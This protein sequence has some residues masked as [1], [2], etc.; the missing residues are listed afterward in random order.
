[1]LNKN[2]SRPHVIIFFFTFKKKQVLTCSLHVRDGPVF[3]GKCQS[4]KKKKKEKGEIASVK[5]LFAEFAR[6]VVKVIMI[7]RSELGHSQYIKYQK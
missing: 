2:F 6:R 4:E 7:L 3:W 1:M 5:E